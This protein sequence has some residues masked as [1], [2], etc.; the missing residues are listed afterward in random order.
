MAQDDVDT[1]FQAA[2]EAGRINGFIMAAADS[3]SGFSLE[4]VVGERTLLSGEKKPQQ[5]DDICFLASATKLLTTIA[6]LKCVE[7]GLLSLDGEL[8]SIMPEL[9][10]KQVLTGFDDNG[11]AILEPVKSPITLKLLLT[12]SS[13]LLYYFLDP[14]IG[15]W[16]KKYTEP[17]QN[18]QSTQKYSVE[19]LMC[20]PLKFQPGE[21]WMYGC[22]IDWAGRIV[23]RVTGT[24]LLEFLKKNVLN[25]LNIQDV[26]FYPVEQDNLRAR[27]VD[28]N[29]KD[30]N[31]TGQAI[32]GGLS[33]HDNTKGDYGGHGMFMTIPDYLKILK[34]ILVND[35]TLLKPATVDRM[36]EDHLSVKAKES[37][38]QILETP[39]SFFRMGTSNGTN[40]GH[41]LGGFLILDDVEGWYGEKTLYWGGGMALSWFIDRKNDLCAVGA[42]QPTV[43]ADMEAINN[44]KATF[45]HDVYRKRE[46][47]KQSQQ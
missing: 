10:E 5:L 9:A 25:P 45:R 38:W 30:P 36:F 12:H 42:I 41:G 4:K 29:P 44:L 6:A 39:Q 43:P 7:Q 23:E 35:G 19:D 21:G 11:E 34:A 3:K 16:R 32:T 28:L 40:V 2:F 14:L 18:P 22:G 46:Q 20:Y 13:G 31:G 27:M 24:T 15:E 1:A 47:W 26:A 17:G 8:S 37:Q 33:P